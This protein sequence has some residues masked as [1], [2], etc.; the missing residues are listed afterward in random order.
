MNIFSKPG[1]YGIPDAMSPSFSE[2]NSSS[3]FLLSW[4]F[5]LPKTQKCGGLFATFATMWT[6]TAAFLCLCFAQSMHQNASW[7]VVE[8]TA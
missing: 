5:A 2:L 8:S 7:M 4:S 3:S 6:F 1:K